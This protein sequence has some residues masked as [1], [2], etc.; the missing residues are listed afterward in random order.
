MLSLALVVLVRRRYS[1]AGRYNEG[2]TLVEF[3]ETKRQVRAENS[4]GAPLTSKDGTTFTVRIDSKQLKGFN[5]MKEHRRNKRR[6]LKERNWLKDPYVR[7][8][9]RTIIPPESVKKV[10]QQKRK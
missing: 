2:N 3:G 8:Q 6:R 7:A 1:D 4:T 10:H 5:R 9:D